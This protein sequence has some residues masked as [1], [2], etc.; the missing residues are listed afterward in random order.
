MLGPLDGLINKQDIADIAVSEDLIINDEDRI[1]VLESMG[2]I[3]VQACPGSGKTTLIATKLILLAKKW[4]FQYQGICVLSHTNVAKDEIIGRLERSKTIEAQRLLSYPHF[5]GTI[6]EFVNRFLAMP[7]LRS[8]GIENITV[9]NDEY[10][11]V[12]RKLLDDGQFAWL[13]GTLNGLGTPENLD[14]FLRDTFRLSTNN[15]A[16]TNVNMSRKPKAWK[17]QAN[18][19]K[20]H[21]ALTRLKQYLDERGF[22]LFRDMYTHAQTVSSENGGLGISVAKRFPYVFLDEM[23]DT[24][25][26]QDELLL[27]IFPLAEPELIV[28]RYG[29]PDQAIFHGVGGEEPN[30]S[31]NG[32][33]VA[34]MDIVINRSHRFDDEIGKKIRGL[35]VIFAG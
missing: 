22:Y 34:D 10:V 35:T 29:D 21:T 2:S 33:S 9:D 30:S 19:Q 24:Q 12:A 14:G 26:Y 11:K 25:K 6:Q 5:I 32:K 23:Q 3:D 1:S 16:D 27:K 17:T 28:Q 8:K 31:Y 20:A 15:G 18:L 13:R 7:Y 4:P